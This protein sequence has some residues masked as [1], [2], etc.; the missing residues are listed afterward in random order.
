M[1][2]ERDEHDAASVH[3]LARDASG[4]PIGT[5]RLLGSGRIGRVAVL[6]QWR[7]RGLGR[8]LM[9]A[10][11]AE[12]S[13]CGMTRLHLHA[14]VQTI[15]FYE[16]LG[17][18][19]C[20]EEFEEAG[21]LHREMERSGPLLRLARLSDLEALES[22]IAH[23]VEIL[24]AGYYNEAQRM[25]AMGPVFGVDPAL[26]EDGTYW[27]AEGED[28]LIAAGGW[29]RR[30]TLFEVRKASCAKKPFSIR[31]SIRPGF[32][33]S[34][35]TRPTPEKGWEARFYGFAKTRSSRPDFAKRRWWRPSPASHFIP[36]TATW[37]END[38]RF[39]C[40]KA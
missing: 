6:R 15:P 24:Q 2:E 21:I 19:V 10:V 12:A 35:F 34:S 26:I 1:E 32:A 28:G 20:G 4:H 37:R 31:R 17:F 3:F 14:Q 23:S 40:P 22:L 18:V 30:K 39:P 38:M 16:S 11:I 8:A 33:R 7:G 36:A 25:A 29:S 9:A 27:V 13:R 5:A